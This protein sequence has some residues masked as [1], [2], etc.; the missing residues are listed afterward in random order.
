[1]GTSLSIIAPG[2]S[3]HYKTT[4]VVASSAVLAAAHFL[5]GDLSNNDSLINLVHLSSFAIWFGSQFW[6]TAVAGLLFI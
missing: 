6:V 4:A 5:P 3:N 2:E 1:M